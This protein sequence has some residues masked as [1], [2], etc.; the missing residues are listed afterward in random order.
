MAI[1]FC[2]GEECNRPCLLSTD[3]DIQ[4]VRT[5]DT[6]PWGEVKPAWKSLDEVI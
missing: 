2:Q 3:D 4:D 5:P 1:F 6:C